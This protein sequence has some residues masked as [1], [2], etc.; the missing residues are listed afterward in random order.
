MTIKGSI[1]S[2]RVH[3]LPMRETAEVTP[4]H[5]PPELEMTIKGSI[6]SVRVYRLPMRETAGVT[7]RAEITPFY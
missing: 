4:P 1:A 7:Q 6:T 3:R 2:V 5:C